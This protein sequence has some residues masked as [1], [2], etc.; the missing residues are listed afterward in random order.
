[1]GIVAPVFPARLF[2]RPRRP[3]CGT[4]GSATLSPR[5]EETKARRVGVRSPLR[6]LLGVMLPSVLIVTPSRLRLFDIEAPAPAGTAFGEPQRALVMVDV[7][8]PTPLIPPAAAASVR[9]VRTV[10]HEEEKPRGPDTG[11]LRT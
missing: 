6:A 10:S 7:L 11:M 8:R 9:V 2:D 1:M 4:G 5:A 3:F